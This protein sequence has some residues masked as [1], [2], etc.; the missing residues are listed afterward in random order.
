MTALKVTRSES[1]ASRDGVHNSIASTPAYCLGFYGYSIAE[2]QLK[3]VA[4]DNVTYVYLRLVYVSGEQILGPVANAL[5]TLFELDDPAPAGDDVVI[6]ETGTTS[7]VNHKFTVT[8]RTTYAPNSDQAFETLPTD[9]NGCVEFAV[10][11]N[12]VGGYL[13]T[14]SIET[15][16]HTGKIVF[17]G[18]VTEIVPEQEPDF[19]ISVVDANGRT[20]AKRLLIALNVQGKAVGSRDEPLLVKIEKATTAG[21]GR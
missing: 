1:G 14:T 12:D 4:M 19:G 18:S 11:P 20:I 5:V 10:S 13:T 8:S 9:A 2:P 7:R 17:E 16:N 6:P 3:A 21:N 15:D